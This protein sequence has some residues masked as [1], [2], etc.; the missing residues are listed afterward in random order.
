M[1]EIG[2]TRSVKELLAI[3]PRD[4]DLDWL[5]QALQLAIELELS[6]LPPYLC[7]RWSI[8]QDAPNTSTS[9]A[10]ER[11]KHIA[12]DEMIHMGDVANMLVAIGGAPSIQTVRL[13]YPCKMP[14]G[15]HPDVDVTLGA[16]TDAQLRLFMTIEE[17]EEPLPSRAQWDATFAT[18]GMFY[19]AIL[20]AFHQLR[21]A[22]SATGQVSSAGAVVTK[23][24]DVDRTIA[25]IM[26]EG[27]GT[28][29]SPSYDGKL[30]HHYQ[31]GEI[32]NK[33]KFLEK[34]EGGWGY[35]G[36]EIP[37][38]VSVYNLTGV[39]PDTDTDGQAFNAKYTEL[40]NHLHATWNGNPAA[41]S[42]SLGS[43][44]GLGPLATAV[45]KK[46]FWPSFKLL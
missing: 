21:P 34:P 12:K 31:F 5:K 11:L 37:F 40:I 14:G 17:P 22:L 2:S 25:K 7:A 36:P 38:P 39:A 20:D 13:S 6:T 41:F 24:E 8:E 10:T 35:I 29:G 45:M 32:L 28:Q 42:S 33:K 3:Q 27:E 26:H 4:V 1:S 19:Q 18:I 30:A 15:V 43:M 9:N 23:I 46:G 16:L 44:F